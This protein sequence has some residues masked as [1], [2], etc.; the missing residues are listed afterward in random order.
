MSFLP[1][2][3]GFKPKRGNGDTVK[4]RRGRPVTRTPNQKATIPARLSL[5]CWDFVK[6]Q[7]DKKFDDSISDTIMRLIRTA[8]MKSVKL[9]KKVDALEE[10]RQHYLLVAE[11]NKQ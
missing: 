3:K 4:K 5:E 11:P 2:E 7:Q 9:R 8:N 1:L 10:E 6:S